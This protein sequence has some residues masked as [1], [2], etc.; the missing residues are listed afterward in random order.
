MVTTIEN[1]VS[2]WLTVP[3]VAELLGVPIGRVHRLIEDKYLIA[4]R[5]DQV[6]K[7]PAEI[8]VDGEPM[9]HL[10]GTMILLS[11]SGFSDDESFAWL[12]K[13]SDELDCTP[14]SAL[15]AGRRAQVRR[16]I[17]SLAF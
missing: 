12:Y 2:N 8:I 13:I 7:I 11:D 6:L 16:A 10:R 14:I 1:Q 5:V 3:E 15:L 9:A 4:T 17:Q